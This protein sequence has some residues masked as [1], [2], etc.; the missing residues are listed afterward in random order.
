MFNYIK[1][2]S[3]T[4]QFEK[5]VDGKVCSFARNEYGYT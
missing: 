5:V 2:N 3:Q 1:I 4:K